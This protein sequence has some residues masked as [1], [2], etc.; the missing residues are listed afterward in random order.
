MPGENIGLI[1]SGA[2][3]EMSALLQSTLNEPTDVAICHVFETNQRTCGAIW[4]GLY[5]PQFDGSL[6]CVQSASSAKFPS[7]FEPEVLVSQVLTDQD[8]TQ[9][10]SNDGFIH[11]ARRL[12]INGPPQVFVASYPAEQFDES[13]FHTIYS[14]LSFAL[15]R[16][17]MYLQLEQAQMQSEK[18]LREVTAL[19]EIGRASEENEIERLLQLIVEKASVVMEAQACSLLLRHHD[20]TL[21][22]AASV[23]LSTDV[24]EETRIPIGKGIAGQVAATGEPMLIVD[25]RNHPKLKDLPVIFN[26]EIS[27]SMCVPLRDEMGH[28]FGIISIRR[29]RPAPIFTEDDLRLFT[30]FANLAALAFNNVQLYASLGHRVRELSTLA[31]LTSAIISP[32]DLPTLLSSIADKIIEVVRFDRCAILLLDRKEML[33]PHILRGYTNGMFPA[34]GLRLGQ[35][36]LGFVANKL[37]P[38]AVNNASEVIQPMK[39][40]ARMLGVNAF[41]AI[42]IPANGRSIGVVVVDKR[43]SGQPIS[44]ADIEVLTTFANQAGMAIETA[45]LYEDMEQ[46]LSQIQRMATFLNNILS[47]VATG[48]ATV[49]RTGEITTWNTAATTIFGQPAR[50]AQAR[51]FTDVFESIFPCIEARRFSQQFNQ[52]LQSGERLFTHLVL[53]FADGRECELNITVSSL[54]YRQGI[55]QGSVVLMEEVTQHA[56]ME[57]K[58]ERMQR[59]A[60]VGQLTATIAHELRNPMTS[61]K[62]AAQLLVN[63]SD[64]PDTSREFVNIILDEVNTLSQIASEFLEFAKPMMLQLDSGDLNKA[65]THIIQ[66]LEPFCAENNVIV[67]TELSDNLPIIKFDQ[68]R[69]SQAARNLIMNAVHAMREGGNLNLNT[70]LHPTEKM[71][72]VSFADSGVGILPEHLDRIFTPFFTTRTKGTGLGLSIVQKIVDAHSGRIAVKSEQGMG[73]TFTLWLPVDK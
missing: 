44:D 61:I 41:V 13:H 67:K 29:L 50:L 12:S 65:I 3:Q 39:G 68:L 56:E 1:E 5:S 52:A 69:F 14:L 48:V 19:Y 73:T 8:Q 38:I 30:V 21:A 17:R 25:P 57:R 15:D 62:G 26:P 6:V 10:R 54:R 63:E 16:Q 37:M 4:S 70:R 58:I 59:L 2:W 7:H 22:I 23:G 28:V 60:E 34:R 20:D 51:Q 40:F 47:S 43:N 31:D 35:S 24:V 42:P 18:R 66:T 55:P 11:L 9:Y 33:I 71:V 64:L 27:S 49:N 45:R 32:L 46:K 53:Q 36:L 72:E